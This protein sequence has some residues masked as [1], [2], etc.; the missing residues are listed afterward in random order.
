VIVVRELMTTLGVG[1]SP[2]PGVFTTATGVPWQAAVVLSILGW[3]AA[4][5]LAL[6]METN[7]QERYRLWVALAKHKAKD[8]QDV[9]LN[10][11]LKDV[12]APPRQVASPSTVPPTSRRTRSARKARDSRSYGEPQSRG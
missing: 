7:R 9:D 1:G 8:G 11:A 4:T 6:R 10:D 2:L 5:I 3:A 12:L